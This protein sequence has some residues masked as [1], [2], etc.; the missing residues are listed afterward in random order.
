MLSTQATSSIVPSIISYAESVF[1]PHII[2]IT[3]AA[4]SPHASS[5]KVGTCHPPERL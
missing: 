5:F 4:F 1:D 3:A 2:L